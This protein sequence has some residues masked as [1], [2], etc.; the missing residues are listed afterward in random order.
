MMPL[1]KIN[2]SLKKQLNNSLLGVFFKLLSNNGIRKMEAW[3][4][5]CLLILFLLILIIIGAILLR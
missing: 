2:K 1:Q 4:I 5:L 3:D